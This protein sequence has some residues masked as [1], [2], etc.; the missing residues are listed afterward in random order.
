MSP[1]HRDNKLASLSDRGAC[2]GGDERGCLPGDNIG[3]A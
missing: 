3:I 2:G 1:T